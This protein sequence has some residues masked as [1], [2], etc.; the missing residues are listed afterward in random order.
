MCVRELFTDHTWAG[1]RI[2]DMGEYV[3]WCR[4]HGFAR[5]EILVWT[6]DEESEMFDC[7]EWG[8]FEQVV[9]DVDVGELLHLSIGFTK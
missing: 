5:Y 9:L 8:T 6:G 4:K 2:S 3:R 1:P 7:P